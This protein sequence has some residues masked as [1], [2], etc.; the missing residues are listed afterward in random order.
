[1][2]MCKMLGTLA[3]VIVW[4][5]VYMHYLQQVIPGYKWDVHEHC[6][7]FISLKMGGKHHP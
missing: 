7:R 3:L 2:R 1:M 4:P 6:E 5:F